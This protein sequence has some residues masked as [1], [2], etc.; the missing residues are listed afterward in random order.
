MIC[1]RK[2]VSLTFLI[3]L[4]MIGGISGAQTQPAAT[5]PAAISPPAISPPAAPMTADQLPDSVLHGDLLAVVVLDLKTGDK[6]AWN[7]SIMVISGG[8][9]AT[10]PLGP[11]D[12]LPMG[13]DQAIGPFFNMGAERVCAGFAVGN[14]SQLEGTIAIRL[15]D[16]ASDNVA[17]KWIRQNVGGA[18]K[19]DHDGQWIVTQ[20]DTNNPVVRTRAPL[21]PQADDVRQDLNCWGDDVPLK[22]V[23]LSSDP[24]RKALTIGGPPPDSIA[25]MVT[26]YWSAKYLYIGARLGVDPNVHIRWVAPDEDGAVAVINAFAQ[27]RTKLKQP[28][29]GT[30]IP[31]AFV[32][33]L[34]Q[35]QPARQANVA[36]VS[37]GEKD[38]ANIFAAVLA[39]SM[40]GGGQQPAQ[41]PVAADWAPTDPAIDTAS[42]QMRLIL[43]A[44]AEYDQQN[45]ALPATLDDLTKARLLPG[46]EVFHNPRTGKD[47]GFIYVKPDA[48]ARLA[49]IRNPEKTAILFEEKDGNADQAGLVGYANGKVTMGK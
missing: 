19:I 28:N 35:V 27:A 7:N 6:T 4:A 42:A 25:P 12:H 36:Q 46:P 3:A 17:D 40:A 16:G 48:A 20:L 38:L 31:P 44:I 2:R 47:N 8:K 39:A 18:V 34:D 24:V 11:N 1:I 9:P 45:H 32:Q 23:Y 15:P 21:S 26:L 29:N 33:V 37:L 13:L 14:G 43:A 30:G 10:R 22:V 5:L 41:T 49:D